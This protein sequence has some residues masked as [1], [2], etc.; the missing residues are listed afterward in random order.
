MDVPYEHIRCDCTERSCPVFPKC[1]FLPTECYPSPEGQV[2]L[3]FVGQGGGRDERKKGRPF[4]GRAGA[5]IR[6]QVA[7]VRHRLSIY[8]GVAFSNTIRD[9]PD[10]NRIPSDEELQKCLP[11]L[12]RDIALLKQRGLGM[13]VLLGNAAKSALIRTGTEGMS[14]DR[15]KIFRIRNGIFEEMPMMPT[16]HPSY[17]MRKYPRFNE[18]VPSHLDRVVIGDIISA[19]EFTRATDVDET[20]LFE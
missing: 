1:C 6:Q 10:G 4:I 11:Y 5:R 7:W 9:N 2:H 14:K 12:F 18:D 15:G 19:F 13:V 8:V 20:T 3:L 16:Y 17:V